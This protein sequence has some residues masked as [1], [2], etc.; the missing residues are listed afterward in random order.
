MKKFIL[1]ILVVVT[2]SMGL[3]QGTEE[4]WQI[5]NNANSGVGASG[6]FFGIT[7]GEGTFWTQL[8]G[9][10]S[11][12]GSAIWGC[13]RTQ[14][15]VI[16]PVGE[17]SLVP[18]AE[19]TV[20]G[21]G[22]VGSL[23]SIDF[24]AIAG[25][26]AFVIVFNIETIEGSTDTPYG[27]FKIWVVNGANNDGVSKEFD[28]VPKWNGTTEEWEYPQPD[29]S[30]NSKPDGTG[31]GGSEGTDLGPILTTSWWEDLMTFLFVPEPGDFDV[32]K[33]SVMQFQTWGPF[34]LIADIASSLGDISSGNMGDKDADF[35]I[36]L[37]TFG[38]GV[39]GLSVPFELDLSP[40]SSWLTLARAIFFGFLMW[41]IGNWWLPKY[42]TLLSRS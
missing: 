42:Q 41:R 15:A 18:I 31:E 16:T 27:T 9:S 37:G 11:S 3:A 33:E 28:Y 34:K 5:Q 40:Y 14:K 24:N 4:D 6:K 8:N 23:S 32:L 26:T 38:F 36:M 35:K 20:D 21:G 29:G 22:S 19:E 13:S 25:I 10:T 7:N 2:A 17:L 39:P 1:L 30:Y 12:S